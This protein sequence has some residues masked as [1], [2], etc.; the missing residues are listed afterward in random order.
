MVPFKNVFHVVYCTPIQ[1]L[2][3]GGGGG[4]LAREVLKHECVESVTVAELD[5]VCQPRIE[6]FRY[7]DIYECKVGI[8]EQGAFLAPS[9]KDENLLTTIYPC[10]MTVI[11][12]DFAL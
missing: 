5:E 2:I 12:I 6:H 1:V 3:I 8:F 7:I 10:H 9:I 4:G 11:V